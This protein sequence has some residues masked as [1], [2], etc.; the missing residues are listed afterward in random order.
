MLIIALFRR[1]RLFSGKCSVAYFNS[2]PTGWAG[3]SPLNK[4]LSV[5]LML[6]I[7]VTIGAL[8]YVITTPHVGERFTE[9]Y[10]LG[11]E[12]KAENYP[13]EVVLGEE[14]KVILGI[15]N[16]ECE[17]VIYWVDVRIDEVINEEIGPLVLAHEEKWEQK[18][19]FAPQEVGE[20]QE[21]EFQLY[22]EGD[23]KTYHTLD[24]WIDVVS[25]R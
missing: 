13:T 23:S 12:G 15:V 22:K 5:V 18:V 19:S 2:N 4:A 24:L 9:F 21:V 16:R 1:G 10:I 25:S 14:A 8:V 17:E 7:L 3:L 20:E 6:A 11:P